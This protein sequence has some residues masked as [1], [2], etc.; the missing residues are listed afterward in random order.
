MAKQED[1]KFL[2]SFINPIGVMI[3]ETAIHTHVIFAE[4]IIRGSIEYTVETSE[5]P[6]VP[7]NTKG[8]VD[9]FVRSMPLD[10]P[11]FLRIVALSDG[12]PLVV[13][14]K[15]IVKYANI[16]GLTYLEDFPE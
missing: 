6:P 1:R 16:S 13:P 14:Q 2:V 5:K 10:F 3:G 4:E 7:K 12:R 9:D 11:I 8:A 15:L